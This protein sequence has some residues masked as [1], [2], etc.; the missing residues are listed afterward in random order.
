MLKISD[1][2]F[3]CEIV[4][5]AVVQAHLTFRRKRGLRNRWIKAIAKAAA[6]IL[7]GDTAFFHWDS[8]SNILYYW[9]PESNGIYQSGESCQ[10]P[11][12]L[13][14][15]VPLP[16]YHR[17]MSRLVKTYFEF[18]QKPGERARIDFADAVFFDPELSARAKAELLD[19]SVLEGRAELIPRV[20]ALKRHF[21]KTNAVNIA[22]K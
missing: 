22:E 18:Q 19:L 2:K 13:R 1:K 5:D 21:T 4:A 16:C 15:P 6:M 17:V 8:D 3:F 14:Q 12:F 10:C 11:A 20:E 7:E 9:S